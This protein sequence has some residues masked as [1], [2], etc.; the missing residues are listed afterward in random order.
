MKEIPL[1]FS[2]RLTAVGVIAIAALGLSAC[3]QSGDAD[4]SDDAK[5]QDPVVIQVASSS[6]P[7]TDVVLA[8]AEVIEDGYEVKLVETSGVFTPNVILNDGEVDANFI[9]HPPHMEDF[10]EGNNGT[11][12]VV[13]PIY[14]VVGGFYAKDLKSFDD[15]ADCAKVSIP[16]DS[17][18]GRAL[19]LLESEGLI[20][21]KKGVDK[22][23]ATV[24][25][26]EKNPKNLEFIAVELANAN[27]SYDEADLTYLLASYARQLEL[28]PDTDALATDQD[29]RFAVSL[30]AREDNVDSPEI[31]ALKRAFTSEKVLETLESFDQ[32]AAFTPAK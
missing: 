17:N 19:G 13:Q 7:M 25:D 8:A 5:S 30:V 15:L 29:D 22:F 31:E 14:Y 4:N 32:P 16:N 10:N 12:A 28:F 3:A 20:T 21:L 27:V 11:L 6:T 23:D 9:Q 1:K 26:V 24:D 2:R 18:Q